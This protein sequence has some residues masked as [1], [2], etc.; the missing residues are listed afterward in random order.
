[1][2]RPTKPRSERSLRASELVAKR[3]KRVRKW[4]AAVEHEE[5]D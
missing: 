2:F 1:M 5:H 4:A 3:V